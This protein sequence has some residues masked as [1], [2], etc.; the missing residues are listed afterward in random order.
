MKKFIAFIF[1]L[2]LF[3]S[4]YVDLTR[5]TLPAAVTVPIQVNEETSSPSQPYFKATVK[6]GQT[7]LSIVEEFN[8]GDTGV[9][10]SKLISDF[11]ALN[12]GTS[13]KTMQV[14]KTY[15]FPSYTN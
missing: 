14:G 13:P 10:V 7:L 11:E 15:L 8:S 12:P 1:S 9:P 5:G 2:A 6:P 3:I 4:V